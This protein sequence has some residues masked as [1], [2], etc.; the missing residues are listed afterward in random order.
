M[1]TIGPGQATTVPRHREWRP[2]WVLTSLL[3]G[4]FLGSVDVSVV[5]VAIPSIRHDL[6]TSGGVLDLVVSGYTLVYAVL[7]ITG[8]RVG[9]VRGRR[10]VYLVGLALF[11]VFSLACG[12]APDGITLV[13]TRIA[14]GV[15]AAL[16]V[17]QVL[18]DIQVRFTEAALRRALGAYTV[19]LGA[20]AVVGQ[21]LGGILVSA[22]LFGSGW[23]PVFLINVPIGVFLLITTFFVLPDDETIRRTKLDLRGAALL[24]LGLSLLVVP[25]VLGQDAG[26]PWWTWVCLG[27]CLPVLAVFAWWERK[28]ACRG[29]EPLMNVALLARWPISL[30]LSAQGVNRACYF[31]MM[32]LITLYLQQGL[33]RGAAYAGAMP[34]A[35]M[36]TFSLSGP[37][38]GRLEVRVRRL[39]ARVGALV[40]AATFV[41]LALGGA[42]STVWLL[43]L[44]GIA[45]ISYG[46]A[47]SGVLAYL[48]ESVE[49]GYAPDVSGLFNTMLQVGGTIGVAAFGT[50]YLGALTHATPTHAYT[51]TNVALAAAAVAVF[52]LISAALK[53]ATKIEGACYVA[54]RDRPTNRPDRTAGRGLRHQPQA[55]TASAGPAHRRR[56]APAGP[57]PRPVGCPS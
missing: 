49:T 35:F 6:N 22:D 23:R 1:N 19:V 42:R 33:G 14:Q 53:A 9:E 50:V 12:L 26:W 2:G 15:G 7:L 25:L 30:G 8:A 55:R 52:I 13:A 48:T 44:L 56:D 32:F 3:G 5:N 45:G 46:G 43:V 18:A 16:M 41:G 34:I 29:N 31:A 47:Y 40:F 39:A 21:A 57:E 10:R 20:G 17:P 11:T 36:V 24:S 51:M 28:V 38:L 4:A 54:I 37:I 27:T